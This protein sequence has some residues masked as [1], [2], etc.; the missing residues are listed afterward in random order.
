[1]NAQ[2]F[3]KHTHGDLRTVAKK[4]PKGKELRF[5]GSTVVLKTNVAMKV[6]EQ[7]NAT[8]RLWQEFKYDLTTAVEIT[9]EEMWASTRPPPTSIPGPPEKSC[10][11][12]V[13]MVTNGPCPICF[14]KV[15]QISGGWWSRFSRWLVG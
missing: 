9:D 10:D 6:T 12:I 7:Y 13:A 2:L 1:M 5:D 4:Y 11:H 14:P 15:Q 8:T 3:E